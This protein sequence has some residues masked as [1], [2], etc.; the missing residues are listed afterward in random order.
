MLSHLANPALRRAEMMVQP[1]KRSEL[2]GQTGHNRSPLPFHTI[3]LIVP[4]DWV[5]DPLSID[6]QQ[7]KSRFAKGF[8]LKSMEFR[9]R[10]TGASIMLFGHAVFIEYTAGEGKI[11]GGLA[12]SERSPRE[13]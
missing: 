13:A 10:M 9:S 5:W 2:F 6:L 12:K 3:V 1:L 4:L 7:T 8:N 11:L